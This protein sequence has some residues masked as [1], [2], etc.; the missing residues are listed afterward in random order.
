MTREIEKGERGREWKRERRGEEV[1]KKENGE[2]E[3]VVGKGRE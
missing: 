3:R 1:G 2:C